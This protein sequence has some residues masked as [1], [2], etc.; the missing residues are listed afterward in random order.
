LLLLSKHFRKA[1]KSHRRGWL[2]GKTDK[3]RKPVRVTACEDCTGSPDQVGCSL[4]CEKF[5]ADARIIRS[6]AQAVKSTLTM[7][8][9]GD[10]MRRNEAGA[11]RLGHLPH[12]NGAVLPR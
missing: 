12:R 9:I 6:L 11:I 5:A 4:P 1:K 3:E 10:A 2:K 8:V 7:L